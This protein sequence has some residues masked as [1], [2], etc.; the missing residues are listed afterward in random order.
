MNGYTVYPHT[1]GEQVFKLYCQRSSFGLS[2]HLWGTAN[3]FLDLKSFERFIPTPVGN[4]RRE[5]NKERRSTVYPH[6]CGEQVFLEC[7]IFQINGLSPHLWGTGP[8]STPYK[9]IARFIP[10]PVGNSSC[11][12]E[13][14]E[15]MPVYPHTCGEQNA[16]PCNRPVSTGLSPHLWGTVIYSPNNNR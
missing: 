15:N 16:M 2:P 1:C 13:I 12:E 10:T 6:T 14:L 8:V 7:C 5:R 11:G 9:L 3:L 4:R